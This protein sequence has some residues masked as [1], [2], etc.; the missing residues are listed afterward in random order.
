MLLNISALFSTV[1]NDPTGD[2]MVESS[3]ESPSRT[4]ASDQTYP[5]LVNLGP[6]VSL[7]DTSFDALNYD[8]DAVVD[9]R[10]ISLHLFEIDVE[11]IF[12]KTG[13]GIARFGLIN[14][15]F[16]LKTLTNGAMEAQFIVESFSVTNTQP[17]ETK[18]RDIMPV[19][20][21]GRNQFML[22]YSSAGQPSHSTMVVVTIDSP[23]IILAIDPVFALASFFSTASQTE[24]ST[25]NRRILN[26][27]HETRDFDL[28][29]DLHDV[30]VSVLETDLNSTTQAIQL[31][32]HQL[33]MSQ[34][35]V[36]SATFDNSAISY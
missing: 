12:S 17:G 27:P 34:H 19:A 28:R 30:S 1:F 35:V 24:V 26:A 32:M 22:L 7:N 20:K 23:H 11:H 5:G 36:F 2:S 25:S 4:S 21:H 14:S 15:S 8:F 33:S 6:E 9:I 31:T 29:L 3:T 13:P 16:R 18:F 10:S